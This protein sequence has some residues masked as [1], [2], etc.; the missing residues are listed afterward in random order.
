MNSATV[1]PTTSAPEA[2]SP[3]LRR[4]CAAVSP[5][6]S[7]PRASTISLLSMVSTSKWMARPESRWR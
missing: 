3:H 6:G 5:A 2:R 1:H 7:A 4:T